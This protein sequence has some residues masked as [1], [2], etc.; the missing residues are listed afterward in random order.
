MI[1]KLNIE[2]LEVVS[3]LLSRT[4]N[5]YYLYEHTESLCEFRKRL[6]DTIKKKK[7]IDNTI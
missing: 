7:E 3:Y 5:I 1:K 2:Q 6:I 4:K